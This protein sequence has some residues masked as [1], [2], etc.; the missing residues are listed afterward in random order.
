MNGAFGQMRVFHTSNERIPKI[1]DSLAERSNFELTYRYTD[2]RADGGYNHRK[3]ADRV[4]RRIWQRVSLTLLHGLL[5]VQEVAPTVRI[6]L[7]CE[8]HS[9]WK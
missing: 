2:G 4:F 1:E 6:Q 9:P 5:T 8:P 3:L 7:S